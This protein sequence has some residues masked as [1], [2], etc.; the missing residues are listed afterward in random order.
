M[1]ASKYSGVGFSKQQYSEGVLIEWV[2]GLGEKLVSGQEEAKVYIPGE[3]DNITNSS[4]KEILDNLYEEILKIKN[5]LNYEVDVEWAFDGEKLYIIQARPITT[6]QEGRA[7]QEAVIRTHPLY[8]DAGIKYKVDLGPCEKI[9]EEYTNKRAPLYILAHQNEI[10]TGI[11]YIL[12]F[13]LRGL[14]ENSEKLKEIFSNAVS[15]KVVI[16]VNKS[17]RQNIINLNELERYLKDMF[18]YGDEYQLHAIIIREY[19]KGEYGFISQKI[20]AEQLLIEGSPD[21]LLAINRGITNCE[22]IIIGTENRALGGKK[23]L[24]TQQAIDK[25]VQFSKVVYSSIGNAK[26]EW[27]LCK[28]IPYFIDFS[29]EDKNTIYYYD[30]K[31]AAKVIYPGSIVASVLNL[32]GAA[33]M[34]RLSVSPGISVN[35]TEESI[36]LNDELLKL[37]EEVKALKEKPIIFVDKPY[38]VLSVLIEHVAGFVFEKGSLLCHLSILLRENKI[39]SAIVNETK[40]RFHDFD[41]VM[42]INGSLLEVN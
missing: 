1:I 10:S 9:Y 38:A 12:E 40:K 32:D 39:P 20:A 34:E 4:V 7:L 16:D 15:D 37:I 2:E 17:I 19:I 18:G 29:V 8:L 5:I 24:F 35:K 22:E 42:L 41:R 26:I 33:L 11:S 3:E 14:M 30:S 25:I 31:N 28:G 27:A 6:L 13:N 21:G 36:K 23:E